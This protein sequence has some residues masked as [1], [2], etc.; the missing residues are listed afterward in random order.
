MQNRR[1]SGVPTCY[2]PIQAYAISGRMRCGA[3]DR[4]HDG[5]MGLPISRKLPTRFHVLGQLPEVALPS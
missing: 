5:L 3:E 4:S 2:P 1:F